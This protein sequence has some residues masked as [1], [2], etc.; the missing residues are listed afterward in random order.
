MHSNELRH[1]IANGD[2]DKIQLIYVHNC[3]ESP[4]VESELV[5]AENNLA[6][7]IKAHTTAAIKLG[8]IELGLTQSLELF[9]GH[10][11]TLAICCPV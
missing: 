11:E 1:S 7:A 2:I 6:S 9:E 10:I 3:P 5:A 8:H 4:N